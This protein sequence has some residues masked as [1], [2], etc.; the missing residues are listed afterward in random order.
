MSK[1]YANITSGPDSF[2]IDGFGFGATTGQV[3]LDNVALPTTVWNDGHIAVTV[4]AGSAVGIHQLRIKSANGMSTVNGL[5][6]H[7]FSSATVSVTPFPVNASPLDTFTNNLTGNLSGNWGSNGGGFNVVNNAGTANDYLRIQSGNSGTSNA[8]WT[9][10]SA[11]GASQEAYFTF[12]KPS[13]TP[14]ARASA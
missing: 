14:G 7:V 2:T 3:F 13:S 1:P 11:F 12:V 8:W 5:T 9:A 10:G 6:F 4:P